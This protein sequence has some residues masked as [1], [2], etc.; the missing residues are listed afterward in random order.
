MLQ[1]NFLK[2]RMSVKNQSFFKIT[3]R[4]IVNIVIKKIIFWGTL[5]SLDDV[6]TRN[7]P[8]A[9]RKYSRELNIEFPHS[10]VYETW[11]ETLI[12]GHNPK[13]KVY[14]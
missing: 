4:E 14:V 13:L 10:I 2:A 6:V 8:N 5:S 11:G 7:H 3:F 12:A 9:K 1:R